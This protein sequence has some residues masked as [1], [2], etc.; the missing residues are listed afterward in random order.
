MT[1][2]TLES[3]FEASI[4]EVVRTVRDLFGGDLVSITLFGSAARGDFDPKRSDLNLLIV[5]KEVGYAE[6]S[7][8]APFVP[9]W[10]RRRIA[11]PVVVSPE[12]L[13]GATDVY[14]IELLEMRLGRRVLYGEDV[15][16][17]VEP[18]REAIRRQCEQDA[19]GKL[20]HL[21]QVL[22]ETGLKPR[23]LLEAMAVSASAFL[24]IGRWLLHLRGGEP[25]TTAD[26]LLRTLRAETGLPLEGIA[27]A[28]RIRSG[29]LKPRRAEI[30]KLFENY[31]SDVLALTQYVDRLATN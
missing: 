19:R 22:L 20:L 15:L 12:Y 14:P 29:D 25:L 30:P 6:L 1:T 10:H 26:E 18:S 5:L 13:S 3:R 23:R 24:R 17:G 27:A 9:R 4:E 2:V 31:L 11:T 16:A 21:R 7:R 28:A 8:L